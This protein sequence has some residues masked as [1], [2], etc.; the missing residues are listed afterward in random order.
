MPAL[1]KASVA[2]VKTVRRRSVAAGDEFSPAPVPETRDLAKLRRAA[3]T[4]RACPLWRNATCTVFGEGPAQARI[5]LVGEQPGDQED[6]Q[7]KPF[8]GPAGRLLDRALQAAGLDRSAVY[9]TNA[10]KHFKWKPQGKRRLH[11]KPGAREIAACRPWLEAEVQALEPDLIV[12]LGATAAQT[13]AGRGVKVLAQRGTKVKTGFGIPA[14][15]T[16]HPSS[17]LRLPPQADRE[18][19]FARFVEDLK[20]AGG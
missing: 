15:I 1:A 19:E 20:K 11:Q 13:V 12:C 10:V 9:V 2:P 6:R 7:G 14:L 4:C 3:A 5:I 18:A 8:V 17:L 16:I